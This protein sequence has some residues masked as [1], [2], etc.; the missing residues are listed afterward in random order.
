MHAVQL[1]MCQSTY[2]D[3]T[4]PFGYRPDLAEKVQPVV[5]KMVMAALGVV[6]G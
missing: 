5:E 4:A 1:E 2:M 6:R 3:E